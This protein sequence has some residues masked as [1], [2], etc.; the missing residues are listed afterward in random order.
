MILVNFPPGKAMILVNFP[1]RKAMFLVNFSPGKAFS[2]LNLK[3]GWILTVPHLPRKLDMID[4]SG[5]DQVMT[6]TFNKRKLSSCSSMY[7]YEIILLKEYIYICI[8]GTCT[9]ITRS[10]HNTVGRCCSIPATRRMRFFPSLM[11]PLKKPTQKASS[12]YHY[13]LLA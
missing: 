4:R 2:L 12:W 6:Q 3:T 5:T 8:H 7:I 10:L 1:P 9:R 11:A 13:L